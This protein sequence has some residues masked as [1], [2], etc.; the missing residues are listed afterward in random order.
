MVD[1]ASTIIDGHTGVQSTENVLWTSTQEPSALS[2]NTLLD[3]LDIRV[4]YI[5]TPGVADEAVEYLG[6]Y[7]RVLGLDIE[8][9]PLPQFVSDPA[10]GLDPHRSSIR[11]VQV[12]A[13]DKQVYVFDI[14]ILGGLKCLK[15]LLA[16]RFVAHN[17]IFEYK[18]FLHAGA[19]PRQIE[20]TM[21]QANVLGGG[22]PS[23]AD[24]A[25][26]RLDWSISKEQQTSDW[27]APTLGT[28]QI[29]Y[30]A[31]DAVVAY[32]LFID[33][34][35]EIRGLGLEQPYQLLRDAQRQVAQLE[36]NGINFDK[37]AH[38]TLVAGWK[39]EFLTAETDLKRLL[40]AEI[41]L[42]SPKQLS[43][44]LEANLDQET[45]VLWPRTKTGL[46]KTGADVLAQFTDLP[47][48]KPL[49]AYKI[50]QKKLSAYGEKFAKHISP[51]TGRIHA[52]FL[53]AGARTGRFSC[54]KPNIQNPPRDLNFRVLFTAAPGNELVVADYSQIELRVAALV[55]QDQVMLEA[56]ER[57]DDL[58][59][60]TAAVIAG[61]SLEDVTGEQRQLAK[62]VN[63]G[64]LFGQG[65]TGLARYART[66]YGVEMTEAEAEEARN[67][68]FET[69]RDL[70]VWQRDTGRL[71]KQ[72][73]RCATPGGRVRDFTKEPHGYRYT[74]ALNT[75][76]QGGAAEVLLATL[77]I[78]DAHL[79]G[80]DAKLVNIVHD[81][82]VL[83]VAEADVE[84]AKAAVVSAM[85]EGMLAIFPDA[86]V[87]D[88][89]EVNSGP[90]WAA[91][92]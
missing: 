15:P 7:E 32:H 42:E 12:F 71:A 72:T 10:G 67:A 22:R 44:W 46:F 89:V 45:Q 68:F 3:E 85:T 92:K 55:A 1:W 74:E 28:E 17:G 69:Y 53:L 59:R 48:I 2:S 51:A 11:L 34:D 38:E 64:L 6:T 29:E 73:N 40:G 39:S 77:A 87:R 23:L 5:T 61:V 35:K 33:Q 30:A 21:L 88:L 19:D 18:H 56:Y 90:N 9:M 27:S 65:A 80:L 70:R 31:L 91:A 20:C 54:S 37:A 58:H 52:S 36:L 16:R 47:I 60:T 49:L 82:L 41:N 66:S 78:L 14:Q 75:P 50:F 62:A 13:G 86:S 76:I 81:E 84:R 43:S 25:A 79:S 24:L 63:F 57:G 26:G 83:E 4:N 8:T